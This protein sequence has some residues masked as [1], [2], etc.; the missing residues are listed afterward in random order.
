MQKTTWIIKK[1]TDYHPPI[2]YGAQ[3]IFIMFIDKKISEFEL[4]NLKISESDPWVK[5]A[6]K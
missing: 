1:D 6:L 4:N 5:L 2:L 3:D